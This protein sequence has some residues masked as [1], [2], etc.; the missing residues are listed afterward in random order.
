MERTWSIELILER[1]RRAC[2]VGPSSLSCK[3]WVIEDMPSWRVVA[4]NTSATRT[5]T[6][7]HLDSFVDAEIS[8]FLGEIMASAIVPAVIAVAVDDGWLEVGDLVDVGSRRVC[9][10]IGQ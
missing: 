5:T 8:D 4:C 10:C 1:L 2:V 9:G 3:R 6:R 7:F